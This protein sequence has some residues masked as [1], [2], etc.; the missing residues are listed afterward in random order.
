M[1]HFISYSESPVRKEVDDLFLEIDSADAPTPNLQR[2][3]SPENSYPFEQKLLLSN[4]YFLDKA[5]A[6]LHKRIKKEPLLLKPKH[7]SDSGLGAEE[8]KQTKNIVK[9][10]GNAIVGFAISSTCVPYIDSLCK[11]ESIKVSEFQKYFTKKK[12]SI[13]GITT[14]R[15]LL[16]ESSRD[17]DFERALKRVFREL[18][19]V[20]VK[21]FSVNW[22]FS[23]KLKH[24][25]AHLRFRYPILRRI[26]KPELFTY[27]KN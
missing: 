17:S 13:S 21:Y 23:G 24:K 2:G 26:Q 5:Y 10:Y 14:F 9:N 19:V 20:F 16:E 12:G 1:D 25:T 22:I 8:T 15:A 18:A 6:D 7:Y 11:R 4:D 3:L 27:L